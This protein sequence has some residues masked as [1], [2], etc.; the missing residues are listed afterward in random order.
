MKIYNEAIQLLKQQDFLKAEKLLRQLTKEDQQADEVKWALGL[1]QI[2]VG[3]P[4]QA[5]TYWQTVKDR[6]HYKIDQQIAKVEQILPKYDEIYETYNQ[7]LVYIKEQQFEQALANFNQCLAFK[8]ALPIEVYE[9]FVNLAYYLDKEDLV[10]EMLKHAPKHV[11]AANKIHRTIQLKKNTQQ[12]IQDNNK[13]E[14]NEKNLQQEVKVARKQRNGILGGGLA[15]VMALLATMVLVNKEDVES[16]VTPIVAESEIKTEV[17]SEKNVQST[18]TEMV[19]ELEQKII[20][21]EEQLTESTESIEQLH[22]KENLLEQKN[23]SLDIILADAQKKQYQT[24]YY[25]YQN[26]QYD[27]AVDLLQKSLQ[28][29]QDVYYAD[30]A[31]Y[32]LI[33]SKIKTGGN[34]LKEDYDRFINNELESYKQSPFYDDILL[35]YAQYEMN[36]DNNDVAKQLLNRV[37]TEYAQEWT[38]KRATLLLNELAEL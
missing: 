35:Q 21:L 18:D 31:H 14:A 11:L 4:Y 12:L 32:Y 27:T 30:D 19:Q 1:I 5:I 37:T 28:F 36:H 29:E 13:F 6:E 23:I 38:A 2:Y 15:L 22:A 16:N 26:G 7:A 25:Y 9:G 33:Q 34:N 10:D 24:G 3:K 8:D 17:V 20:T